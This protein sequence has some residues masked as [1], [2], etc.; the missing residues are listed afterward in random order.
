MIPMLLDF[1]TVFFLVSG[2][3]LLWWNLRRRADVVVTSAVV[4]YS[5]P[6]KIVSQSPLTLLSSRFN[7]QLGHQS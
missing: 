5:P 3:L 1:L 6:E 4:S 2:S 7:L